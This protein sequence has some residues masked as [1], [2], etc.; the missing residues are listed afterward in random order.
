MTALSGKVLPATH[1]ANMQHLQK[2]LQW[3]LADTQQQALSREAERMD[4]W[5][6]DKHGHSI[7]QRVHRTRW[8]R[9]P[10]REHAE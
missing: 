9:P 2:C 3:V 1:K 6:A 7:R 5:M 10:T 8:Q 4:G